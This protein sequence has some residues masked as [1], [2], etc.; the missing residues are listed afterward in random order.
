MKF[1]CLIKIKVTLVLL[2]F[3]YKKYSTKRLEYFLLNQFYDE[4]LLLRYER[5]MEI[6][7]DVKDFI[8]GELD[9]KCC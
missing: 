4:G 2:C 6:F 5:E 3:Y 8:D 1:E 7:I 9:S